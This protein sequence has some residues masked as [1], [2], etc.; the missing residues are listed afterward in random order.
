MPLDVICLIFGLLRTEDSVAFAL[1]CQGLSDHLFADSQRIFKAASL[2]DKY[3]V[4][5]MLEKD[6]RPSE[7]YCHYC[8]KFHD[9]YD[10]HY[11]N[12]ICLEKDTFP[13]SSFFT[14]SPGGASLQLRYLDARRAMNAVLFDRPSAKASLD[15]LRREITVAGPSFC[16]KQAWIP[17]VIDGEL[18][19]RID[20]THVHNKGEEF[21]VDLCKHVVLKG[22]F[23]SLWVQASQLSRLT[24]IFDFM[25]KEVD[26]VALATCPHCHTDW[27]LETG[28]MGDDKESSEHRAWCIRIWAWHRL[29]NVRSPYDDVWARSAGDERNSDDTWVEEDSVCVTRSREYYPQP[30]R[31]ISPGDLSVLGNTQRLWVSNEEEKSEEGSNGEESNGEESNDEDAK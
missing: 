25:R 14:F 18:L 22:A 5:T 17:K 2:E 24:R 31:L 6:L 11:R 30:P 23:P 4:Q 1:V 15:S 10:E 21:T 12:N 3:K 28:S 19:L 26:C 8:R 9:L 13:S 7:V 29:G 20:S 27:Q 16:W